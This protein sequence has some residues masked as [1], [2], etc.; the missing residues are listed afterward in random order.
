VIAHLALMVLFLLVVL[1]WASGRWAT[2]RHPISERD[3]QAAARWR[4]RFDLRHDDP[5]TASLDVVL[6]DGHPAGPGAPGTQECLP[7]PGRDVYN[8]EVSRRHEAARPRDYIYGVGLVAGA[9]LISLTVY[10]AIEPANM[11][12]LYLAA[13]VAAGLYLGRGPALLASVLSTVAFDFFLIPPHLTLVVADTQY[14]LTFAGLLVVGLV[15][16]SLAARSREQT[17]VAR[18]R[19][20]EAVALYE[21]GRALAAAADLPTILHTVV[22]HVHQS[23]GAE[24]VILL[25]EEAALQP[26]AATPGLLWSDTELAAATRAYASSQPAGPAPDVHS[27]PG[28]RYAPLRTSERTVGV[29]GVQWS[30]DEGPLPA[31]EQR[32]LEA[33]ANLAAISLERLALAEQAEQVELLQATENLQS[34]LLNSLSHELRTPLATITGVLSSLQ[35]PAQDS[36]QLPYAQETQRQLVDTALEEAQRLNH[37]VGNLL[38]MTRLQAGALRLHREPCDLQDLV[39]TVLTQLGDRLSQH[40]VSVSVAPDLPLVPLDFVLVAQV[41][42]NLLDN[43][44]KYTPPGTPVEIGAEGLPEA[45]T[46]SVRDRGPG[47][48]E[49]DL[50]RVFDKFQRLAGA[51]GVTGTGLGLPI[52]RGIIEAHGG[53]ISAHPRPG[54][55]LEVRFTLPLEPDEGADH[56]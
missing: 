20:A 45:V 23:F 17:Q 56:E 42:T 44:A 26:A 38:D 48:P 24:V 46:V 29:L 37:L 32:L 43:A 18:R 28:F 30:H 7:H 6:R 39:G 5:L 4:E 3:L 40:P 10:R 50:E 51:T 36:A 22:E 14:L 33:C 41:L 13:V 16:S 9:T 34:A 53:R 12:M 54:G 1:Y 31:D 2:W 25:P 27:G 21:L 35:Q 19:Q 15:I 55:G 52:S 47:I 11:V 8:T 49:A